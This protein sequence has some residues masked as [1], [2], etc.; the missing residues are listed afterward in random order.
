M[1]KTKRKA[2]ARKRKAKRRSP[3]A[4]GADIA[5]AAKRLTR[6]V[7]ELRAELKRIKRALKK[8]R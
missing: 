1:A 6:K 8:R 4:S 7:D 3:A 2:G 5:K